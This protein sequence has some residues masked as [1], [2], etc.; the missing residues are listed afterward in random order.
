[1]PDYPIT[2]IKSRIIHIADMLKIPAAKKKEA[3]VKTRAQYPTPVQNLLD[4]YGAIEREFQVT[5]RDSDFVVGR[6]QLLN[7]FNHETLHAVITNKVSWIHDLGESEETLVD[8]IM[9]R[10]L[11]FQFVRD[12]NLVEKLMPW[13]KPNIAKDVAD[14]EGYG[15]HLTE[16]QYADILGTWE[17]KY[18]VPEAIEQMARWLLEEHRQGRILIDLKNT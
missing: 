1:M 7:I 8:E 4:A 9:V 12:A 15:I 16:R 2:I 5:I 17:T 13:Y 6:Q 3:A 14:C 10:V 18:G 11:N